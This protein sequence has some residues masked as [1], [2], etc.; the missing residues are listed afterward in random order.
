MSHSFANQGITALGS[1]CYSLWVGLPSR[2]GLG[3]LPIR[4][5]A[6]DAASK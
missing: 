4:M 2:K 3:D 1:S 6:G 5:M